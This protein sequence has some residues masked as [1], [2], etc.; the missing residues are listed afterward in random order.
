[1]E[2]VPAGQ[3]L[4]PGIAAGRKTGAASPRP[5]GRLARRLPGEMCWR[6]G[7][8]D[9]TGD[10]GIAADAVDGVSRIHRCGRSRPAVYPRRQSGPGIP[11][12]G[13]TSPL[14]AAAGAES[15]AQDCGTASW[16]RYPM[17]R[18]S[19]RSGWNLPPVATGFSMPEPPSARPSPQPDKDPLPRPRIRRSGSARP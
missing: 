2:P 3:R 13:K 11:P 17:N 9:V 7:L 1:M 5:T 8:P 6:V 18:S 10:V 14:L 12:P 16:I 15:G 4:G 19:R